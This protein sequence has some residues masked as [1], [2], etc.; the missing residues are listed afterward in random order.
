MHALKMGLTERLPH[1]PTGTGC[2]FGHYPLRTVQP[3]GEPFL[4]QGD[5]KLLV[6]PAP[7]R[8]CRALVDRV[9]STLTAVAGGRPVAGTLGKSD[10]RRD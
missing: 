3:V 4:F 2:F 6:P 10:N 5:F 9:N 8:M 7:G 1:L